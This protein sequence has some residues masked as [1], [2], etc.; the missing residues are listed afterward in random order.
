MAEH[1]IE[2]LPIVDGAGKLKG[3]ITLK[4]FVKADKYPNASKD[5]QGRLRVG[6]AVG[7][8]GDSWERAMALVA[9]GVDCII[10]DTAHGHSRAWST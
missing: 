5:G 1:K 2:K 9:E 4:D 3:L 8:F 6:A 7:F 10:V